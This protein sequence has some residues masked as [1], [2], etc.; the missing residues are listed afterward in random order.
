[1]E[2]L[3]R[4]V[5]ANLPWVIFLLIFAVIILQRSQLFLILLFIIAYIINCNN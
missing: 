2:Y 3:F 1:M 5:D 4:K